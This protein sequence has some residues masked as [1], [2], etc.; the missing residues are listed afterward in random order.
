MSTAAILTF[1]VAFLVS[2]ALQVYG[3]YLSFKKKWYIGLAS[4]LVPG[5]ALV[6]GAMKFFMKKDLA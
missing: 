3:M 1:I 5:F 2:L 6:V 4:V